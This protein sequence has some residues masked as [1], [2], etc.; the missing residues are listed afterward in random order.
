MPKDVHDNSQVLLRYFCR[1]YCLLRQKKD[2]GDRVRKMI[3]TAMVYNIPYIP[4]DE[5][6]R[7]CL[8]CR[9]TCGFSIEAV[10]ISMK[11]LAEHR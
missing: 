2:F 5:P 10:A 3:L 4:C 1:H 8:N 7:S 9:K 11:N 6:T